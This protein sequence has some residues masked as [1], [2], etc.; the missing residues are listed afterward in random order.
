MWVKPEWN[1]TTFPTYA[2][3]ACTR[4]QLITVLV[5]KSQIRDFKSFTF[6]A[7]R[8]FDIATG[9]TT[10][11]SWFDS[12][13]YCNIYVISQGF[14]P[15]TKPTQSPVKCKVGQL[16]LGI[17]QPGREAVQS[18]A[19]TKNMNA[20]RYTSATLVPAYT[21][22]IL[23]FFYFLFIIIS[24]KNKGGFFD[25]LLRRPGFNHR[26]VHMGFVVDKVSLGLIFLRP[27]PSSSIRTIP[28]LP[29][30]HPLIN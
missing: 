2:F 8:L 10:R 18:L 4:T 24:R 5:D 14:I 22:V 29:H 21:A 1:C 25:V 17:K 11:D 20:W 27:L 28:P 13:Q 30:I 15:T 26:P 12:P 23:L 16:S 6:C 19:R 7:S 3:T 9:L